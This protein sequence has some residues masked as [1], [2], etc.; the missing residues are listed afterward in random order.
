MRRTKLILVEGLPG[1]GKSTLA[2]YLTWCL[3]AGSVDVRWWYEEELGHPVYVFHDRDSLRE[4]VAS[5]TQ[6]GY[7]TVVD[8]ALAQWR[9]F[10]GM[11]ANEKRVVLLDSCLFGYLTWSLF[12]LGV[13]ETEIES[14]VAE[15]ARIMAPVDPCLIYLYQDDVGA[16]LRRVCDRRGSATKQRLMEQSTQSRYGQRHQLSGFDGMVEYWN[17][18]RRLTD[19]MY[20]SFAFPK[21]AIETTAGDWAAYQRRALALLDLPPRDAP[22]LSPA[23]LCAFT[24]VYDDPVDGGA[25]T[26]AL[27]E[28]GLILHGMPEVWQ[29]TPLWPLAVD[30]FAVESLPFEL[31]FECG[32]NGECQMLVDGPELIGGALPR[33]L[34]RRSE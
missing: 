26:V 20:R 19:A 30:R 4:T 33:L 27:G 8:A 12:P 5:L 21:I 11:V 7:A 32:A 16:S 22:Q 24:G 34:V 23:A 2:Q 13:P 31:R 18:Y 17:A 10:A 1:S 15:V 3:K 9:R 28:T 14:Y 6:G 25:V 29:A